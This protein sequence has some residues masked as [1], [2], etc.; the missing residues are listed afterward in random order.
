MRERSWLV[1]ST[2]VERSAAAAAKQ[3][4]HGDEPAVGPVVLE[5]QERRA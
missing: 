5:F 4:W 3:G 1:P 2:P